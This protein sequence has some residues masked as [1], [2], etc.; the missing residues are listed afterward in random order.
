MTNPARSGSVVPLGECSARESGGSIYGLFP[1]AQAAANGIEQGDELV[2]GYD[3]E[4]NTVL[5][6][7][8]TAV[9]PGHWAEDWI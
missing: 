3:G 1:A 7:P 8:K 4:S 5:M 6:S 9:E 2:L